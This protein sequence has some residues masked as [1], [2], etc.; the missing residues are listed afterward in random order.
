MNPPAPEML[1]LSTNETE[2]RTTFVKLIVEL[3]AALIAAQSSPPP[4]P[5][6]L[7][8]PFDA[9]GNPDREFYRAVPYLVDSDGDGYSDFTEL[10]GNSDPFGFNSRPTDAD[11]D[12]FSLQEENAAGTADGSPASRPGPGFIVPYL[13]IQGPVITEFVADNKSGLFNTGGVP[14]AH[15]DWI[16]IYNPTNQELSLSNWYLTDNNGGSAANRGKWG[17]PSG[18]TIPPKGFIIVIA[19]LLGDYPVLPN[20]QDRRGP[21]A[22]GR[23][24][25]NFNLSREGDYLALNRWDDNNGNG[26]KDSNEFTPAWTWNSQNGV[27]FKLQREDMS[28]GYFVTP[29]G[30]LQFGYLNHP[31]PGRFNGEGYAE[32]LEPPDFIDPGTWEPVEGGLRGSPPAGGLPLRIS[33]PLNRD[34]DPA[35]DV[36]ILWTENGAVPTEFSSFHDTQAP[37]TMVEDFSGDVSQWFG[38]NGGVWS[39]AHPVSNEKAAFT[40]HEDNENENKEG[41]IY[42]ISNPSTGPLRLMRNVTLGAGTWRLEFEARGDGDFRSLQFGLSYTGGPTQTVSLTPENQRFTMDFTKASGE[43]TSVFFD[44]QGSTVGVY[45]DNVILHRAD[46]TGMNLTGSKVLR[47]IAM[48]NGAGTS[49]VATR[50]FLFKDSVTGVKNAAGTATGFQN[51]YTLEAAGWPTKTE[52]ATGR[53]HI[54]HY[55]ALRMPDDPGDMTWLQNHIT[56]H[57]DAIRDA[58]SPVPPQAAVA[59]T[60]PTVCLTVPVGDFFDYQ[61]GGIYA[62]GAETAT[63]SADPLSRDWERTAHVEFFNLIGRPAVSADCEIS[64]SGF[65]SNSNGSTPKHGL[66]LKFQ[67]SG[68]EA[69][70]FRDI[71]EAFENLALRETSIDS[72]CFRYDAGASRKDAFYFKEAW[73][74]RV[75]EE[76]GQPVARQRWAHLYINGL[77]WGVYELS[78]RVDPDFMEQHNP[79]VGSWDVLTARGANGGALLGAVSATLSEETAARNDWIAFIGLCEAVRNAAT[80][81][82]RHAAYEAVLEKL[83]VANYI[84]YI[85]VSCYASN[86]DWPVNN[87]RAARS[88]DT[89]AQAFQKRYRFFVWDSE[90]AFLNLNTGD[91]FAKLDPFHVSNLADWDF[92]RETLMV[93]EQFPLKRPWGDCA[94]P[95][96]ALLP[97]EEF[98]QTLAE[99]L[100]KHFGTNGIFD[101]SAPTTMRAREIFEEEAEKFLQVLPAE[102]MRWGRVR[103]I[104]APSGGKDLFGEYQ[105]WSYR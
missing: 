93:G 21:D 95:L 105:L 22:Q 44:A 77:Y 45:F 40:V 50:T 42:S 89:A 41:Y 14:P 52:V 65:T 98:R 34:A 27:S 5:P 71:S 12:G 3:R 63:A 29:E 97:S 4:P 85:L 10:A 23:F 104:N 75:Q 25:T 100:R 8:H 94:Q 13:N 73:A 30:A 6:P 57:F 79:G 101:I 15:D 46:G 9:Y 7:R 87:W 76:M 48:R 78:E 32:M 2:Q 19:D 28:M 49:P 59:E 39:D 17:F 69:P 66:R 61:T 88:R 16:E 24:H 82:A 33:H 18:A 51:H 1:A 53:E 102:S 103:A 72:W 35:N 38:E 86:V 70:I 68:L 20:S 31:T 90:W 47:A 55:S 83:D 54:I 58:L 60:V 81:E 64:I 96:H 92:Y 84:D 11:K 67:G 91:F 43:A 36:V 26:V 74:H 80:P 56:T 37:A 62:R 99:Q